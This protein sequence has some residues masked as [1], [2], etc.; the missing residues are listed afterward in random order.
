M[1]SISGAAPICQA[2]CQSLGGG[3]KDPETHP[4]SNETADSGPQSPRAHGWL[5][6]GRGG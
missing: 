4:R 2:L 6:P 1:A 3:E 5:W